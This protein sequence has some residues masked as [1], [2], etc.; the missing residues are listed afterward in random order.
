MIVLLVGK[1]EG[2]CFSPTWDWNMQK[3]GN[4][5]LKI[6]VSSGGK[7]QSA[8]HFWARPRTYHSW[9]GSQNVSCIWWH[10]LV[11]EL[12]AEMGTVADLWSFSL[13]LLSFT[14]TLPYI[15]HTFLLFHQYKA[16]QFKEVPWRN[17]AAIFWNNLS[18]QAAVIWG[19]PTM[20]HT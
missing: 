15:N 12:R 20:P 8:V 14:V 7:D 9:V 2:C 19:M 18:L 13:F 16:L 11:A 10:F 6:F 17:T 1:V 5:I 4:K 3:Q